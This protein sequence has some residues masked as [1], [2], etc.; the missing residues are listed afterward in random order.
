MNN[1]KENEGL[2]R[3]KILRIILFILRCKIA[4]AEKKARKLTIGEVEK[5]IAY[6]EKHKHN[7][8]LIERV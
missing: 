2:L 4:L 6:L 3:T 5:E 1:S 7:L 8:S